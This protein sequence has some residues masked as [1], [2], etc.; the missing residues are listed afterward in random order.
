MSSAT[1]R[2]Q[3]FIFDLMGRLRLH[4]VTTALHER[5][6]KHR[7]RLED[8]TRAEAS[9]LIDDLKAELREHWKEQP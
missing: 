4:A 2:Q 5:G 9:Q 8:L 1:E 6:L 7:D 3:A